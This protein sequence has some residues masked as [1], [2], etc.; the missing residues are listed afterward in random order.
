MR[1][2]V[3]QPTAKVLEAEEYFRLMR[4][5]GWVTRF[6]TATVVTLLLVTTGCSALI[7]PSML[8]TETGE[9]DRWVVAVSQ[10]R[11]DGEELCGQDPSVESAVVSADLPSSNYGI[12]LKSEATEVD[13]TRI[14]ECLQDALVSGEIGV[15]SP[16]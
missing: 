1:V 10:P 2:P 8:A 15:F 9:S 12:R 6:I 5:I 16:R 13:A 7:Q 4:L 14:A 3:R 11:F